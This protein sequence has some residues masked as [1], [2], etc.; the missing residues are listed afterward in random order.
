MSGIKNFEETTL[1]KFQALILACENRIKFKPFSMAF[2]QTHTQRTQRERERER[3][4][5]ICI[6]LSP[7]HLGNWIGE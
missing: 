5:E 1:L 7:S 2:S 4:R 6:F 3:E